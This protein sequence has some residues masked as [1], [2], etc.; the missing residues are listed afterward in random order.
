MFNNL[1]DSLQNA[2]R[3]ITGRSQLTESNMNE[4]MEDVR[5]ALL[6]ADVNY[7]IACQ[8]VDEVRQECIGQSVLKSVTPGQQA[9]K[10]VNDKLV[11]LMGESNVPLNL[12]GKPAVIMLCGLHGSGKTT[13][14]AKLAS[15]LHKKFKKRVMLAACD[16]YRPAAID[17][18]EVLGKELGVPVFSDRNN[19]NVTEIARQAV[20][21]ATRKDCDVVILDTAGRLQIDE[22]LVQ[23]LVDIKNA[24]NPQEI[25]LVGDS[26][27]GQEA[28]SVAEHFNNALSITGIILT[29]LDGDARGGAA[30][31]MRQVTGRPIKFVTSGEQVADLEAFYPDRMAS[32]IL[33]MGDIVGIVERAQEQFKEEEAKELERKMREATFGFD[34]F[35]DQLNKIKRM[36]GF[37]NLLKLLPGMNNIP[38]EALD[39]SKFK[40]VEAII[41]S[42]TPGERR[43]PDTIDTSRRR[44]IAKGSGTSEDEVNAQIAQ[45]M[46]MRKM[47]QQLSRGG[48][49]G[50]GNMFGGGMP[51]LGGMG[52]MGGG[53][54]GGMGGMGG[55][56]RPQQS[57]SAAAKAA[58]KRK[59]EKAARKKNRRH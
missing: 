35:L 28:V 37:M 55:G 49:G 46:Q 11:A 14:T 23:E 2:F 38:P 44:R 48:L 19:K 3:K 29:K 36:G 12:D 30:L 21:E 53:F 7:Q 50:L 54:P 41:S 59:Q 47:M 5:N 27:L 6:D 9:I 40:R 43:L 34:D 17:Q 24:V 16:L 58:A 22:V 31:S 1:T 18:L 4:A 42:M 10:I 56:F 39:E 32:R 13:T 33:G 51:N 26:A 45:F 8:F 25:L 15:Y 52:G 20:A 57:A